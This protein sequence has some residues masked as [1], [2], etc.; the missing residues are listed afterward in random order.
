MTLIFK[1]NYKNKKGKLFLDN[2]VFEGSI[3][4]PKFYWKHLKEEFTKEEIQHAVAD[5]VR[6]KDLPVPNSNISERRFAQAAYQLRKVDSNA[7]IKYAKGRVFTRKTYAY[8]MSDYFIQTG[9]SGNLVSD[10]FHRGNRMKCG[11]FKFASPY[12]AWHSRKLLMYCLNAMWSM[13][14][15][16]M[17]PTTLFNCLALRQYAASQFRVTAAMALYD[18]FQAE[19]VLDTSMGW[20]DRLAGFCFSKKGKSYYGIDPNFRLHDGYRAQIKWYGKGRQFIFNDCGSENAWYPKE[21]ADFSFTSPP[22]FETERYG[23]D[24]DDAQ[25]WVKFKSVHSWLENF[26]FETIDRTWYALKPGGYMALNIADLGDSYDSTDICDPMNDYISSLD[27]A[28]YAGCLG[29]RL[30]ARPHTGLKKRNNEGKKA[31]FV[32]PIW[33]WRKGEESTIENVVSEYRLMRSF[34]GSNER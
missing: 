3:F 11:T 10:Y 31:V 15:P 17:S 18:L 4:I 7:L 26:L 23:E 22:Y 13:K 28:N 33:V 24:T 19:D 34:G 25:S 29:L 9:G 30:S 20:G 8:P 2:F 21:T 16:E 1:P 14:F 12:V 27:G 32:E 5:L 6:R